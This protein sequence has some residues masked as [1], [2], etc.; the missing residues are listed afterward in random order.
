MKCPN[1]GKDMKDKSHAE[2]IFFC[3]GDEP[4][5]Y[6][7]EWIEEYWCRDCKIKYTKHEYQNDEWKIPKKYERATDKQIKCAQ[8]INRSL[9]TDFIPVLKH[10]TWQ[11]IKKN[12]TA[13]KEVAQQRFCNWCED[14]ADWLPEYF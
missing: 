14:N 11:F 5:Y 1:C 10:S 8:F 4:D 2:T 13:A 3:T 12:L 6:P 9:G 7:T